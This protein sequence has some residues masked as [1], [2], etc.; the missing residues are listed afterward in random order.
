MSWGGC[1]YLVHHHPAKR[2]WASLSYGMLVD[3]WTRHIGRAGHFRPDPGVSAMMCAR[4]GVLQE[5][6]KENGLG[7]GNEEET[8][9]GWPLCAFHFISN[10]TYRR[11]PAPIARI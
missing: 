5:R 11:R 1:C 10:H 6:R 2:L 8:R 4:D 9:S 3:P 7:E